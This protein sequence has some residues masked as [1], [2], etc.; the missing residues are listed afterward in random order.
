MIPHGGAALQRLRGEFKK[1]ADFWQVE[2][3]EFRAPGATQVRLSGRLGS[4][5][6]LFSGPVSV[7]TADSRT[8]IGWLTA[9]TRRCR[10]TVACTQ[11]AM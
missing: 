1:D 4:K 3:L 2:S 6:L 8:L 9:A 11:E 10:P 5:E 7:E